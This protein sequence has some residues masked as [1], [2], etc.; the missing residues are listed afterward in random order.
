MKKIFMVIIA[1]GVSFLCCSQRGLDVVSNLKQGSVV[2][3]PLSSKL[4]TSVTVVETKV[5]PVESLGQSVVEKTVVGKGLGPDGKP[6]VLPTDV[7]P[8][9][10]AGGG[11]E[12][13]MGG[14]D[15]TEG[16]DDQSVD[17][18]LLPFLPPLIVE[19]TIEQ[20][21]QEAYSELIAKVGDIKTFYKRRYPGLWSL[22]DNFKEVFKTESQIEEE[23]VYSTLGGSFEAVSDFKTLLFDI[24]EDIDEYKANKSG[25]TF[26]IMLGSLSRDDVLPI[27]NFYYDVNHALEKLGGVSDI[28]GLRDLSVMVQDFYNKWR[29]IVLA[30]QGILR[31]ISDVC[32][33]YIAIEED[34]DRDDDREQYMN[35]IINKANLVNNLDLYENEQVCKTDLCK[36][37]RELRKLQKDILKKSNDLLDALVP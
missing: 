30:L 1:L 35:D 28:Q 22:N 24:H 2:R 25:E 14:E 8:G 36:M 10:E 12:K 31:E 18:Q 6:I 13:G 27:I 33:E 20:Q 37:R 3:P 4:P 32:E 9:G 15:V 19:K 34:D 16:T 11:D 29:A 17:E 26:H 7:A 23:D 5:K 21:L